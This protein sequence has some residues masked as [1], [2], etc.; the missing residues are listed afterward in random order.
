MGAGVR[1]WHASSFYI[2]GRIIFGYISGKGFPGARFRDSIPA[3]FSRLARFT[4]FTLLSSAVVSLCL[5]AAADARGARAAERAA[6]QSEKESRTPAQQKINSQLLYEIYRR[7]GEAE[8]K[9]VP[10]GATLVRV[11]PKGRA[12]VDVRATVTSTLLRRI[13][14]LGGTV[15][16][17]TAAGASTIA[18][19]PLLKLERL[20]EDRAVRA[21]E[22]A[23][24]AMTVRESTLRGSP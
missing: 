5:A 16:T 6:L 22:P 15:V 18:W 23:A 11:D 4:V 3:S 12:L 9:G 1:R 21:I 10:P 2:T 24:E 20:A 7:R 14:R 8:K 17:A 19:I 13:R